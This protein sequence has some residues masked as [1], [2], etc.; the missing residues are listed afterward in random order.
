[1]AFIAYV[2]KSQ[3]SKFGK[4]VAKV[5]R[6]KGDMEE[7]FRRRI[8]SNGHTQGIYTDSRFARSYTFEKYWKRNAGYWV[9]L[10]KK[11]DL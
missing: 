1:M 6:A 4:Q 11:K 5:A 7:V 9:V 3:R 8:R 10:F 2:P